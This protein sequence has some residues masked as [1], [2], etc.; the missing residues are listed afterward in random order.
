MA[1][2][3]FFHR[4]GP[5][6]LAQLAEACGAR[7]AFGS[8]AKKMI[9]DVAALDTAGPSQISF[10]DNPKYADAFRTSGAGACIIHEKHHDKAP[11]GMAILLSTDPYTA[12]A[13]IAQLFY[14]GEVVDPEISP[15]AHIDYRAILGKGCRI[16]AGAVIAAH[17]VV[18]AATHVHS[19]AVIGEGVK[20]G[21]ECRIG[22]NTTISHAVLG[23]RVL[24]HPG[25]RI[26]QDGFGF[27]P[28]PQGL[29]KV[30]QLGRVVIGNDVEI[31]ANSCVDRGAG[32]DTIIGDGTKI[33]NLVQVGHNVEIGRFCAIAAQ[34]GFAGSTKIGDGVMVG[35]Q[36]GVAGHLVI[37]GGAKIAAGGGVIRDVPAGATV[38][39]YPAVPVKQW[40]RQAVVLSKLV[41][42]KDIKDNE[43]DE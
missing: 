21:K 3:R 37:G 38:A 28:S 30:P 16:D 23:D 13:R 35:G 41:T 25:V 12:Y 9:E 29:L 10:L 1:D 34:A 2:P 11:K 27:A 4:S 39:G 19:G 26:G 5:F 31:G 18:G 15:H 40:H 33:D 43:A 17:A 7:L 20:I 32:P 22:A 36:A 6:S 8:D 24:L 14:P 42:G